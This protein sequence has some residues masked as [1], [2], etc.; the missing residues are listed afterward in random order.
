MDFLV[1]RA[2]Q[3]LYDHT[4]YGTQR[5]FHQ[6][7]FSSVHQFEIKKKHFLAHQEFMGY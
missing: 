6:F 3:R 2:I 1:Q 5:I 7:C 4:A